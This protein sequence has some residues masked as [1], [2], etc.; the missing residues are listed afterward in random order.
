MEK[1][2][3]TLLQLY[4]SW[5]NWKTNEMLIEEN[6]YMV[7]KMKTVHAVQRRV[8]TRGSFH[9]DHMFQDYRLPHVNSKQVLSIVC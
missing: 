9:M 7:Y 5:N 3:P 4:I 1:M 8:Q 2:E 6:G